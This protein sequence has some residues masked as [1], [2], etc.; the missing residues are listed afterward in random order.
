M[1][2]LTPQHQ[3]NAFEPEPPQRLR[4]LYEQLFATYGPQHWWPART[5]FE[6]IIGA[7]L[8]QNTSWRGVTRS[9]A[10]LENA[11]PENAIR[12]PGT[13]AVS[14]LTVAGLRALPLEDLRVLIRPSGYMVRKAAALKAFVAFLDEQHAGSLE[15]L[16]A[17]PT[18]SLRLRLLVL[19]GVGPETADVILLYALGHPV[20]VVDEYL[21][22]I[23]IRHG[24]APEKAKY[25]ELQQLALTAFADDHKSTL[26]RHFNE[27]HALIVEAGKNH[28]GPTPRCSG[29]PLETLLP[30]SAGPRPDIFANIQTP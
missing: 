29:C 28:C 16:A 17:Q 6:V 10:N 1:P 8:V 23:A 9:I 21:R 30:E 11:F 18:S 3:A 5:P 19:P 27:F 7:Y 24:L 13:P 14:A 4:S 22:R 2:Y 26:L 15:Q 20:M 12:E 25:D